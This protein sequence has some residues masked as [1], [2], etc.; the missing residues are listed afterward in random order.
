MKGFLDLKGRHV[1]LH[2]SVAKEPVSNKRRQKIETRALLARI[3][4]CKKLSWMPD[5]E[6]NVR[7]AAREIPDHSGISLNPLKV[8]AIFGSTA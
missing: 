7:Y 6:G 8:Q 2:I 3:W 5:N 4:L 1:R